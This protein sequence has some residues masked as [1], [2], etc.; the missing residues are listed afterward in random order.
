MT[1][2]IKIIPNDQADHSNFKLRVVCSCQFQALARTQESAD[3]Y[4][5]NHLVRH[6]VTDAV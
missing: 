5:R 6:G 4:K 1:H 3:A 2:N